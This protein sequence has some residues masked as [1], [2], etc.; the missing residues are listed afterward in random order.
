MTAGGLTLFVVGCFVVATLGYRINSTPSLPEGIWKVDA[1][2]GPVRRGQVLN[3][4]P[5]DTDIF[6]LA[7]SRHYLSWGAYPGGYVSLLKPVAA[8]PGDR[9]AITGEGVA[10]NGVLLPNSRTMSKDSM[11]RALPAVK[12]GTYLVRPGTVWLISSC[13]KSFDSRYF[14]PLPSANILGIAK[15]ILVGGFSK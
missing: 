5:P 11:E 6:Q 1:P 9:V 7:R 14:G 13:S 10:V 8:I 3:I 2:I 4:Q 15:P 12:A